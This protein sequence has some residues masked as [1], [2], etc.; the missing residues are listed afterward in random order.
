MYADILQLAMSR[1]SAVD[2]ASDNELDDLGLIPDRGKRF[3]STASRPTLGLTQPF[4]EWV[5]GAFLQ[6]V[7]SHLHVLPLPRMVELYLHSLYIAW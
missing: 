4:I 1:V 2:I 3:F 7:N 5:L 6:R